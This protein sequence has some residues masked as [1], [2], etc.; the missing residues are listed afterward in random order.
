[1]V[2]TE[3]SLGLTFVKRSLGLS[4]PSI[5]IIDPSV[6]VS[7]ST[8]GTGTTATLALTHAANVFVAIVLGLY[9]SGQVL[10]SVAVSGANSATP[11][12]VFGGPDTFV[13]YYYAANAGTDNIT[14][15]WS[16][17]HDFKAIAVSVKAG[18]SVGV[19]LLQGSSFRIT[20]N[21]LDFDGVTSVD[22]SSNVVTLIDANNLSVT[23]AASPVND[24]VGHWHL[25]VQLPAMC[26]VGEW[27]ILWAATF[28]DGLTFIEDLAFNVSAT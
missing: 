1:M 4:A 14:W 15:V 17:S 3:R 9:S 6:D 27:L 18:V 19:P 26:A 22:P 13:Y 23:I 25:D 8:T 7:N 2:G 10:T 21:I 24:T 5:G 12:V 11:T 16:T 28:A 20:T